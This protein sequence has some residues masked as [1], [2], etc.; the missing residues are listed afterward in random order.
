MRN[1]WVHKLK[2]YTW[3]NSFCPIIN[4]FYGSETCVFLLRVLVPVFKSSFTEFFV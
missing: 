2:N 3:P 4:I 1:K